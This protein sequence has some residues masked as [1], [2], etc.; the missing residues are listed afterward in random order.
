M[1]TVSQNLISKPSI[2]HSAEWYEGFMNLRMKSP[3]ESKLGYSKEI[4]VLD[5]EVIEVTKLAEK[6]KWSSYF[7]KAYSGEARKLKLNSYDPEESRMFIAKIGNKELGFIRITN[8]TDYFQG[9]YSG[10]IWGIAEVYVKPPYRSHGVASKLMKYVLRHNQ[11]KSIFLEE[12][13]YKEKKRYFN[14]FGFT[15]E[16]RSGNGLSRCYLNSFEEVIS[17][18][19]S[20]INRSSMLFS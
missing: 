11:V 6:I 16:V 5:P 20:E 2:T 15:Y 19:V 9:L 7:I 4:G 17:K 10:E 3:S 14:K 18:K 12:D 8:H 13:R 1:K